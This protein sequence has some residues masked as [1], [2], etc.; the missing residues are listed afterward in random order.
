MKRILIGVALLLGLSACSQ[1]ETA[2][3]NP[4]SSDVASRQA[5]M[6]DWRFATDIV[7]GM[8]ENPTNFDSAALQEQTQFLN[9]SA[10]TMWSYFD[11]E[12]AQGNAKTDVW[13]DPSA[14]AE[15]KDRFDAAV[16]ALNAAAQ[17]AT[18]ASDI[19]AAFG[20][21]GESCGSCHKQFK[22]R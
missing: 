10:A 5:L 1:T 8:I 2:A 19:E 16:T 3:Q 7:K 13:S 15:S 22:Q 9:Q 12:S 11:D 21:V 6:Q 4:A 17:S 18:Q 14:F 20:Q